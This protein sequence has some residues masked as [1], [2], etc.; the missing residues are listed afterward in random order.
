MSADMKSKH[1]PKFSQHFHPLNPLVSHPQ[2]FKVG[3]Y[4]GQTV[5][6]DTKV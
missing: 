6:G 4:K 5:K 2:G 3:S 1:P